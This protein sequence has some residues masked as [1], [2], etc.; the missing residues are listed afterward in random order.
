MFR[1]AD[2][3]RF[4]VPRSAAVQNKKKS[5]EQEKKFGNQLKI[6]KHN[7]KDFGIIFEIS[8]KYFLSYFVSNFNLNS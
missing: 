5:S 7:F 2:R 4:C 8:L 1:N 6:F 3:S